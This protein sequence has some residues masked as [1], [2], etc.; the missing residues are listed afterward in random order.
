MARSIPSKSIPSYADG[1]RWVQDTPT[2]I[3]GISLLY[4][5]RNYDMGQTHKRVGQYYNDDGTI[6]QAI[7]IQPW[8]LVNLF[9]NYTIKG[10]SYLRGS[11]IQLAL[12]NL[13]NS[14]AITGIIAATAG[15][16][17]APF[18]P[19]PGDQLNLLPGRS[20]SIT[21]TGGYAP[22]R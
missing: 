8:E 6:N 17:A 20:V 7:A 11:K 5:H 15:T 2:D 18:M 19:A 9:F 14:H 3:E 12:N 16:L 13:A 22:R 4:Q 1:G 21:I 10:Q